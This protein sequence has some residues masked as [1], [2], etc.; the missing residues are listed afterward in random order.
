MV[1][2]R[3]EKPI[4]A[5]PLPPLPPPPPS[6]SQKVFN[7]AFE[8]VPMLVRLTMALSCPLKEDRLALPL[9]T[10]LLQEIA[11]VMSLACAHRQRLKLLK[12][13]DLPISKPLVRVVI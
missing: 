8:T 2:V 9:S 5:T 12:T 3:S 6:V 10:P 1:S 13:S 11:G 7:V 4:C